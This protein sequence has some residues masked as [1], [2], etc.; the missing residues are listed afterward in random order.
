MTIQHAFYY[1]SPPYRPYHGFWSIYTELIRKS[2]H[3]FI[4]FSY[5]LATLRFYFWQSLTSKRCIAFFFTIHTRQDNLHGLSSNFFHFGS[6]FMIVYLAAIRKNSKVGNVQVKPNNRV[7]FR[8]FV[9]FFSE[10]N[11]YKEFPTYITRND[12]R[13]N[14]SFELFW[15]SLI[16]TNS[17]SLGSFKSLLSN[18]AITPF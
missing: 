16:F 13:F 6:E 7:H 11:R 3:W 8:K 10:K 15:W 12:G 14:D 1:V 4:I 9:H 5:N 18:K 2:I 17:F